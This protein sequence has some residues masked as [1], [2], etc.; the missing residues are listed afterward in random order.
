MEFLY[1]DFLYIFKS[2]FV[3]EV[4]E[5]EQ[6]NEIAFQS[7]DDKHNKKVEGLNDVAILSSKSKYLNYRDK[8]FRK[9]MARFLQA[10]EPRKYYPGEIIQD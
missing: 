9:H 8:K 7:F 2:H 10:L 5:L 6:A 1:V 4:E 3:N